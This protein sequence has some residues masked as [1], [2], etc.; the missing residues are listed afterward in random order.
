MRD[1]ARSAYPDECC[2]ILLG[3]GGMIAWAWPAVN[4]HPA[5]HSHFEIAPDALIAAHRN[6]RQ[7]GPSVAGYY[8]SHPNGRT[9]PSPDDR[10]SAA[11]DGRV[12]MILSRAAHG[13]WTIR[14][15]RDAP[16]GFEPLSIVNGPPGGGQA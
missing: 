4:V 16:G 14:A 13:H 3:E 12:W 2:G 6:A 10:A 8:H 15:W 7:G 5:P 1:H 11:G 9:E